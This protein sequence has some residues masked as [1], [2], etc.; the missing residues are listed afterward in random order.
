MI[1]SDISSLAVLLRLTNQRRRH[2]RITAPQNARDPIR[3]ITRILQPFQFHA[4]RLARVT[5]STNL[6]VHLA[7]LSPRPSSDCHQCALFLFPLLH[8][9]DRLVAT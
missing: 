6:I 9:D 3:Q 4:D 7:I 5:G 2:T 8:I 1:P